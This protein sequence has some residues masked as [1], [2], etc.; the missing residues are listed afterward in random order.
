MP[1]YLPSVANLLAQYGLVAVGI[2]TFFEGETILILAGALAS[3]NLL[4]L[5]GVLLVAAL[6]A[7]VGHLTFFVIGRWLG[8]ERVIQRFPRW[9]SGLDRVDR[10][11]TE[12]PWS[13]IFS[14]QYLYGMRVVGAIALGMSR[15]PIAWFLFAEAL[16]C[17]IWAALIGSIGYFVGTQAEAL[18]HG[19]L[20]SVWILLSILI[21]ILIYF[22]I[23]RAK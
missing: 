9:K 8:K 21:V 6:G 1:A 5:V 15:I 13:S 2:G 4:P 19:S 12:R 22:R 18:F 11:I 23:V 14:L 17:L 3:R 7:W 20:R 10:F 16:N